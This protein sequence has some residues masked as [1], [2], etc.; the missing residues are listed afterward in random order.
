MDFYN[1]A[2]LVLDRLDARKGSLKSIVFDLAARRSAWPTRSKGKGRDD[3]T[4]DGRRVSDAK[5]LL[6]VSVEV[7]KCTLSL[8]CGLE[9]AQEPRAVR[10]ALRD[11][12][13]GSGLLSREAR[14]FKAPS[15]LQALHPTPV[16]LA[17]VL[18]HDFIF[19]KRGIA[20]S[21][22]HRFRVLFERQ[23]KALDAAKARVKSA[24]GVRDDAGLAS[25]S[26]H[27]GARDRKPRWLRVNTR[28]WPVEEALASFKA[29]GYTVVDSVDEIWPSS[30]KLHVDA[31][32]PYLFALHPDTAL[33]TLESY[34]DGRL[35]VQEKA[36]CFP[37]ALLLADAASAEV[38]VIDATAAPG[39]K[40]TLLSALT[41]GK[42]WAFERDRKRFLT[43]SKMLSI[44]GCDGAHFSFLSRH[45]TLRVSQAS[46]ASTKTSL[47]SSH[48]IHA[49]QK[50]LAS[51]STPH[52]VRRLT[53]PPFRRH[54][55]SLGHSRLWH[56]LPARPPP[57]SGR[58]R[59]RPTCLALLLPN[60]AP[61]PCPPIP[62]GDQGRLF[63]LQPP[64]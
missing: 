59:R 23:R 60:P 6:K 40:T 62:F 17:T 48:L 24:R 46:A 38:N 28:K 58:S 4:N 53:E 44:A 32:L 25:T 1:K 34:R 15:G 30:Q 2:G 11:I 37:P 35:I 61:P 41:R 29:L 33:A 22:D 51:S 56:R 26:D 19:A 10:Q 55:T 5:R 18:L 16:S 12:I 49:S 7:L 39:N 42:V 3:V 45:A 13:D 52:A 57:T 64:R 20:L 54:L 36:S 31:H 21:K 43:L 50:S 8:S 14:A 9:S 27:D 63:H 47:P